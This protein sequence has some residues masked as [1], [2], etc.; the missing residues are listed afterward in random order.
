MEQIAGS[1]YYFSYPVEGMDDMV[2]Y[3]HF[4][5]DD[6]GIG[7]VYY[8]GYAWNQITF[9]GT[10]TIQEAEF[11]YEVQEE[12]DGEMI[13]G[14]APYTVT[15]YDWDGNV[16]DNAGYDGEFFYNSTTAINT[17][18]ET[19]GGQFKMAKADDAVLEQYASTF[20]G[21]V[22]SAYQNFIDPNDASTYVTLNT[23]GTYEDMVIM[24]VEGTWAQ[25][26][27][28]AYTL[29]P[30]SESDNGAEITLQDDGTYKYV[31]AD[32]TE[33]SLT[34]EV[35]PEE[36][37]KFAGK[38]DVQGMEADLVIT[39]YTDNTC[40]VNASLQGAEVEVDKGTYT[41]GE[42]GATYTFAFEK[43]GEIVS[44]FGGDTGVQVHYVQAGSEQLGDIDVMLGVVLE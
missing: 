20:E 21:E 31:S 7:A 38:I 3:F 1:Y 6:L 33:V 24:A 22:G 39:T 13:S 2:A 27:E 4:Y 16:V 17:A 44:E 43:A 14:T 23:N 28:G 41:V 37:F 5:G 11:A 9:S 15:F 42:D 25:T 35:G 30:N 29:T 32:G 10:Y 34:L 36:G 26:G 19:G 18:G 8:A 12:K 40:T